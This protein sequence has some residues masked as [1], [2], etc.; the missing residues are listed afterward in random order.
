M[1]KL[2]CPEC[3]KVQK[4]EV[5]IAHNER[6]YTCTECGY[7]YAEPARLHVRRSQATRR[8]ASHQPADGRWR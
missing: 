7:Q 1:E 6:V 3:Q 2:L 4:F 8:H 5:V